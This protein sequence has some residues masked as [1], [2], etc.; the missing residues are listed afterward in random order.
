MISALDLH[1]TSD[2]TNIDDISSSM[3]YGVVF[4]VDAAQHDAGW[5]EA[6]RQLHALEDRLEKGVPVLVLGNN[7]YFYGASTWPNWSVT[8]I[9]MPLLIYLPT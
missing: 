8:S 2:S 3:P 6:A 5:D 1:D 7:Y 4:V 9:M